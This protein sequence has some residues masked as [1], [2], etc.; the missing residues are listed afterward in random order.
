MS[1]A[2]PAAS[3]YIAEDNP[4]L[5]QGLQRAVTAYGY[6]VETAHDG[7]TMLAM[8]GAPDARPDILLLDLM[9]PGMSGLDLLST[10]REDPRWRDLPVILITAATAEELA[11]TDADTDGVEVLLKPFRL[12]DL[13][14][15]L[16]AHVR[17]GAP[18]PSRIGEGRG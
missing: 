14:E 2:R 8:L 16:A 4:I 12:T 7:P 11:G 9:M 5:L 6:R 1:E 17:P 3:I 15:R 13:L 10:L 18:G